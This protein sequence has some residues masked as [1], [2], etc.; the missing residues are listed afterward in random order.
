MTM[1]SDSPRD[2]E[3]LIVLARNFDG[4]ARLPRRLSLA[5]CRVSS[6]AARGATL[7]ASSF[8]AERLPG[9]LDVDAA[10]ERLRRVL[11]VKAYDWVV[12]GDDVILDRAVQRRGEPWLGRLLPL[13]DP[14]A[15]E[16]LI[17]K[18]AFS[19]AMGAAGVA[20]PPARAAS[21]GTEIRE[22]ALSLGFPVIVK[23]DRGFS[24]ENIFAARCAEDLEKGL[25]SARGDYIVERLIEGR[26]GATPVL[27]NAGRPSW[28]TSFTTDGVRPPP[29]GSSC[30]RRPF[31][32]EGIESILQRMGAALGLHGLCGVDWMQSSDG[33]LRVIELNG[34]PTPIASSDPHANEAFSAAVRDFLEGRFVARR[35]PAASSSVVTH[36]MPASFL[37]AC[38]EGHWLTAAGLLLGLSG[39]TDTPWEDFGLLKKHAFRMAKT[40]I[41]TFYKRTP[42]ALKRRLDPA[43]DALVGVWRRWRY[44]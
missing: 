19:R 6:L 38:D 42:L 8:V 28:W 31:E 11:E 5:G 26:M 37:L 27:F 22:A 18:A 25:E 10:L 23:P 9:T 13:A 41:R 20:M 17:S 29:F 32:P 30:R 39:K 1:P 43:V 12:F 24:G 3:V 21:N 44:S 7:A 35:P 2:K 16:A 34:R 33:D 15:G 4:I 36:A 14:G 40:V